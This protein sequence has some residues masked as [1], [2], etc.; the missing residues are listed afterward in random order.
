MIKLNKSEER[1]ILA[2][3]VILTLA[4]AILKFAV[5][6]PDDVKVY[7]SKPGKESSK[8]AVEPK[9]IYVYV[10]GEV[11]KPGVYMMEE[12]S[13]ISDAVKSAGGFTDNAD[14]ASVNLA[15]KISDEQQINIV[16]ANVNTS[17]GGSGAAGNSSIHG[18]KININT[19]AAEELDSFLPGIGE[20]LS[21][22]IVNYRTKNG[23]FKSIDD[24]KKVDGIGSGRF[25]KIKDYITVN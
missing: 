23:R 25:E 24:I 19:A 10:T 21:K 18:G 7:D 11:K 12:G 16:P 9:R 17:D 1:I 6:K 14:T 22:N 13:R 2:V 3:I 15:E 8:V 5:F 20:G 4:A